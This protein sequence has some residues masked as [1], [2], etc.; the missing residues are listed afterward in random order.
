[1]SYTNI[2]IQY[3]H[4]TGIK[5]FILN[6]HRWS[7]LLLLYKIDYVHVKNVRIES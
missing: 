6:E 1:M 2:C 3:N 7:N 4:W 5:I